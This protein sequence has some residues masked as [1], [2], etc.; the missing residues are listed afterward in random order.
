VLAIICF[1][2]VK[3]S[4]FRIFFQRGVYVKRADI[5]LT[6][7]LTVLSCPSWADGG[8]DYKT[9]CFACHNTGV[10]GAPKVG[11]INACE[12]R[13]KQ[14]MDTL[15]ANAL[16]PAG[17]QGKSGFM[18]PRGGSSLSDDAIKAIVDYMVVESQ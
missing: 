16:N 8:S 12:P 17:F 11:D 5:L 15:Y 1:I 3:S 10:A 2:Q 7:V 14:G 13:I 18:P 6:A 4:F 9:V